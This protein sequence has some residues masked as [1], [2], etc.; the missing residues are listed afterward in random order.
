MA[1]FP[2]VRA[3]GLWTALSQLTNDEMETFDAHQSKALNAEE[4]GTWAPSSRIILGGE[5]LELRATL[6][7]G[8]GGGQ[9]GALEV[10]DG[11][12]ASWLSGSALL[13]Y[14]GANWIL[15]GN[16]AIGGA[17]TDANGGAGH[18]VVN[19]GK[20]YVDNGATVKVRVGGTLQVAGICI[21]D[22]G[23]EVRL[24][25]ETRQYLGEFILSDTVPMT[26]HGDVTIKSDGTFTAESGST[27]TLAGS[28]IVSGTVQTSGTGSITVKANG[29]FTSEA[30]ATVSHAGDVDVGGTLDVSGTL[31]VSGEF[32]QTG[33]IVKSGSTAYTCDRVGDALDA[34]GTYG[35]EKDLWL[36]PALA[37]N[38][39]YTLKSTSPAPPEG[40]RVRFVGPRTGMGAVVTF[41]REDAST[42]AVLN[43]GT[44]PWVEFVFHGGSW[45]Y[46]GAGVLPP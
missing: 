42:A 44:G 25:G 9:D 37:S 8:N 19:G 3:P 2:R 23:S 45:R 46:A 28:T 32:D 14:A 36:I 10:R 12:G 30:L 34:D 13:Q 27:T 20:L 43:D 22:T 1:S 4:G 5:G 41:E 39:T 7:I 35:A 31:T 16:T 24:Y 21:A 11:S 26:L 15:D 6:G 38:R 29:S 40:V 18:H 17:G 33:K